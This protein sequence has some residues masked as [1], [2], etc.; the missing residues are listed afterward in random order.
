MTNGV[1]M[2]YALTDEQ[3][4]E[5]Q[6]QGG[7]LPAVRIV[8]KSAVPRLEAEGFVVC[9]AAGNPVASEPDQGGGGGQSL[10]PV[11]GIG[12]GV[13]PVEGDDD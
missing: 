12:S 6:E 2:I 4:A 10:A 3:R 11:G 8:H 1:H 9:D 7:E 5:I 13:Q